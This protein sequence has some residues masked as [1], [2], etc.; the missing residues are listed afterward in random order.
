MLSKL[1]TQRKNRAGQQDY[2]QLTLSLDEKVA[3]PPSNIPLCSPSL[4]MSLERKTSSSAGWSATTAVAASEGPAQGVGSE[5]NEALNQSA[6]NP[7]AP[8]PGTGKSKALPVKAR[9]EA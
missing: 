7:S 6:G 9:R 2:P 4:R 8:V 3:L 1:R 5:D